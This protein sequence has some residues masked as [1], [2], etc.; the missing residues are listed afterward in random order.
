VK[1]SGTRIA[2]RYD[3]QMRVVAAN[4]VEGEWLAVRIEGTFAHREPAQLGCV[5]GGAELAFT[6]KLVDL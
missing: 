6:G 3:I 1:C 4:T 2:S 5:S